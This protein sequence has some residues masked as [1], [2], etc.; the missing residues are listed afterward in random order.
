MPEHYFTEVGS[1]LRRL[2][3]NGGYP[4]ARIQL[5]L[6]RSLSQPNRR[7]SVRPLVA[8]AWTMRHNLTLADALYVVV[9]RHLGAPLVTADLKLAGAPKLSIETITP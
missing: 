6:D 8:E 3:R 1:V 9:A 7:V 5:A 4:P 2:E